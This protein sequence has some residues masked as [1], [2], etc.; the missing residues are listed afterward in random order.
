VSRDGGLLV[1]H[2][3]RRRGRGDLRLD[4][5]ELRLVTAALLADLV[6]R[7]RGTSGVGPLPRVLRE[8]S[9]T[10]LVFALRRRHESRERT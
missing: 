6:R 3:E 2:R 10:R 1:D 9:D 7:A 4:D 8:G 5:R